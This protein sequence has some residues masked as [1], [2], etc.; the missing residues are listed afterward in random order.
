[1][2][3]AVYCQHVLGIGHL[4]R[5]L[6]IARALAPHEVLLLSGGRD[7]DLPLP[8]HVR[9]HRLPALVSDARFGAWHTADGRPVATVLE[10]RRRQLQEI[11]RRERPDVFLVELYPFGRKAFRGELDPLLAHLAEQAPACRVV[12]SL[13]DILV[14]KDAQDRHEARAAATLNRWFHLLLVH[15]DPAVVRLEATFG[16]L[17][18]LRVPIRYTGFVAPPRPEGNRADWRRCLGVAPGERL[19]VAG[20][21]GGKV[22]AELLQAAADALAHLPP[23]PPLRLQIFTGP[24]AAPG[25]AAAL[26]ARDPARIRAQAFSTEWRGWLTAADLSLSMAG[27][28]TCMDLLVTGVPALVWPLDLNREQPLRAELLEARGRLRRLAAADLAPARLAGIMEAAMQRPPRPTA[29]VDLD[30]ASTSAALIGQLA[31]EAHA[32]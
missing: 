10:E 9:I 31:R 12:C 21:G 25:L 32:S 29:P 17:A 8:A 18:E 15:A 22:G 7:L 28:N 4:F 24:F 19:V 1:M 14:E 27:Y 6:E 26:M 5:I 30:G 3:I 16:R 2:K 13:R 23:G 20:A 11:F